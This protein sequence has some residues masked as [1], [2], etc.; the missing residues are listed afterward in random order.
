MDF[1]KFNFLIQSHDAELVTKWQRQ[2][3]NLNLKIQFAPSYEEIDFYLNQEPFEVIILDG[4]LDPTK[5]YEQINRIAIKYPFLWAVKIVMIGPELSGLS[6]SAIQS[7][8]VTTIEIKKDSLLLELLKSCYSIINEYFRVDAIVT[9]QHIPSSRFEFYKTL[10]NDQLPERDFHKILSQVPM[11]N[12][13]DLIIIYAQLYHYKVTG[14]LMVQQE[15]RVSAVHFN[16]GQICKVDAEDQAAW[17]TKIESKSSMTDLNPE[18]EGLKGFDLLQAT[19]LSLTLNSMGTSLAFTKQ[20]SDYF[21]TQ[22][23]SEDAFFEA[24]SKWMT[25]KVKKSWLHLFFLNWETHYF[26]LT[27]KYNS[28]HFIFESEVVKMFKPFLHELESA[29]SWPDLIIRSELPIEVLQKAILLLVLTQQITISN[30]KLSFNAN[31]RRAQLQEIYH[32]FYKLDEQKFIRYLRE[33]LLISHHDFNEWIRLYSEH[34]GARPPN[35]YPEMQALWDYLWKMGEH[36]IANYNQQITSDQRHKIIELKNYYLEQRAKELE[37][38][39][40]QAILAEQYNVASTVID[41]MI[42]AEVNIDGLFLMKIWMNLETNSDMQNLEWWDKISYE[43][44]LEIDYYYLR[45]LQAYK[46]QD[47]K[48]ATT[49]Y[50]KVLSLDPMYKRLTPSI[51]IELE[52]DQGIWRSLLT[53]VQKIISEF[54]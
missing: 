54:K 46:N 1:N 13:Y 5:T 8:E 49:Y 21:S 10:L 14:V 4:C 20:S 45:G 3:K 34:L 25:A 19:L 35:L 15:D 33:T 7:Q 27:P 9:S 26:Y 12:G 28:S 17:Q 31:H 44:R 48:T 51:R 38:N 50:K 53:K 2:A 24:L 43:D 47:I 42:Q 40:N 39:F 36:A 18:L 23:M 16:Q 37:E 30:E 32:H 52:L 6:A 41:E 11:F 29:K 22:Q